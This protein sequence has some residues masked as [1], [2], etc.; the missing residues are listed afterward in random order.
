MGDKEMTPS[1]ALSSRM[2]KL[3]PGSSSGFE[4]VPANVGAQPGVTTRSINP[5]APVARPAP[6]G[7]GAIRPHSSTPNSAGPQ[8]APGVRAAKDAAKDKNSA[9]RRQKEPVAGL[10]RVVPRDYLP[11]END[12]PAQTSGP[13]GAPTSIAPPR[14]NLIER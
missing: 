6:T 3:E 14:Q 5:A 13:I 11:E 1:D 12:P 7:P 2:N 10:P 4:P 9:F 8:Q